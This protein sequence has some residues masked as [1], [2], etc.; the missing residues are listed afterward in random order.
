MAICG[1]GFVSLF[2]GGAIDLFSH[3]TSV[4]ARSLA[5]VVPLGCYLYVLWFALAARSA[6]THAIEEGVSAA[7]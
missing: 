1:G 5:F 7:H 3:V 4:G 6:P 2:Y